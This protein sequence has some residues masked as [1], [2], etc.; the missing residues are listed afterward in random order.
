M[1]AEQ[2][3]PIAGAVRRVEI[4]GTPHGFA[5][6]I[7]GERTNG[8]FVVGATRALVPLGG[9]KLPGVP[10][11]VLTAGGALPVASV[12][13]PGRCPVVAGDRKSAHGGRAIMLSAGGQSPRTIGGPFGA[14]L[15]GLPLP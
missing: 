15:A 10:L 4:A 1:T 6:R 14:G 2:A 7:E 11:A 12:V 3:I 9:A 13:V 5:Y 8:R